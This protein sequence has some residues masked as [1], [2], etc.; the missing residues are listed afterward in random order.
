MK[1]GKRIVQ[2]SSPNHVYI[3]KEIIRAERSMLLVVK[4]NRPPRVW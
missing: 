4:T 3:A 1:E 2:S